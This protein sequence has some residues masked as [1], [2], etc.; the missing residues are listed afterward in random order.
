MILLRKWFVLFALVLGFAGITQRT[1]GQSEKTNGDSGPSA[2]AAAS[3]AEVEELRKEL[4][5]QRRTI[6]KLEFLVEQLTDIKSRAPAP[7]AEGPHI[8]NAVMPLPASAPATLAPV[9]PD[10]VPATRGGWR[11]SAAMA[12]AAST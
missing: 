11:T 9:A 2:S 10:G 1:L 12:R 6:E 5:A 3:K 7:A 8:V 4:A